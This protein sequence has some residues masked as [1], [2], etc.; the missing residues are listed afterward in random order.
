M[1]EKKVREAIELIKDRRQQENEYFRFD[2]S[3]M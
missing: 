3:R 1:N 2:N